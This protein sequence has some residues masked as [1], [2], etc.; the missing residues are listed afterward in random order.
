VE[1]TGFKVCLSSTQPAA[2][3]RGWLGVGERE[4]E[5]AQREA[6]GRGRVGGWAVR[7]HEGPGGGARRDERDP[8]HGGGR[9][10]HVDERRHAHD[11]VRRPSQR[12]DAHQGE[13][14]QVVELCLTRSL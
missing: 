8:A 6:D 12:R 10:P 5:L 9:Q 14:V 11:A 2:L 1:N 13:A 4:R 7:E 3:R